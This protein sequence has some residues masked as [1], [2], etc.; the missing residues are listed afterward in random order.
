MDD[1]STDWPRALSTRIG[2]AIRSTREQ[3]NVSASKLAELTRSLGYPIH[4][5]ALGRMEEGERDVTIAELVVIAAALNTVPTALAIPVFAPGAEVIPATDTTPAVDA[6]ASAPDVEVL[7]GR[8]MP[9]S[10]AVGWFT[11]LSTSNPAG[12]ERVPAAT[13]A[14]DQVLELIS[15]DERLRTY[16][17]MPPPG[18]DSAAVDAHRALIAGLQEWRDGIAGSLGMDSD[19]G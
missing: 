19:G 11:G 10:A 14:L 17:Q 5:V 12:I 2:A 1:A 3:Q 15:A 8:P 7:P 16:R 18:G 6:P 4:R 13:W 9:P